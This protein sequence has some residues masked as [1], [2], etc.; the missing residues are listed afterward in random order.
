MQFRKRLFDL[1]VG[2]GLALNAGLALAQKGETVKL[3]FIDPLSGLMASV[4]QNQVRSFQFFADKFNNDPKLNPAGVKYEVIAFDNKL[5]PTES[6]TALKAAIDQGVRY[7]TQGDGSS[8]AAALIDAVGKHND[9]NP[10]QEIV[11]LNHSAVDPDFT[12]SKCSYW[13]FRFDADTSMK[14]EAMTTFIKDLPDVK[15]VYLLNQNYTHG[16]Q[17]AKF[18]K[19]I[20]K[21]KRPDIQIVGEDLHQL[22]QVR[23]FSPYIAKIKATGADT[24]I[25]GNWGSDLTLLMKAANEGGYNG[26]FFTYYTGVSGTPTAIGKSFGGKIFQVSYNHYNMG[27][28][29]S[30][31]QAEYKK[32]FND[33]FYTGSVI[34]IFNALSQSIAKAKS[35][36]PV[37]VAAALEGLKFKSFNGDVEMRRADHQLQQTLYMT[38]WQKA[39]AEFPYSPENTG[40]TLAPVETFAP[41]VSSTPTSCQMKRPSSGPA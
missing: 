28:Q 30:E 15:K 35:T 4:G 38:T 22:A 24:V 39:T 41:Y 2:A 40:M 37:K 29:M 13:H 32:K 5:S 11:Y 10:G 7:I 31:W 23:D 34:H 21:R 33:D 1:V 36:D 19:E 12:N 25:T 20:L 18:A 17:V 8:V 3:A 9:R 16:H 6:L 27:G 14:M 26:K